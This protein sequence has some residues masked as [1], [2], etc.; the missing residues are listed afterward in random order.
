MRAQL[1]H[2]SGPL[3]GRTVT[4]QGQLVRIGAAA[5]NDVELPTAGVAAH[6]ATIEYDEPSC[7]FRLRRQ[8]GQ[9]FVNRQEVEEV[10]LD[11]DDLI[12]WGLNGPQSRCVG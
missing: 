5:G 7:C 2:L 8:D 3:R 1:L 10:V 4:Y 11:M 12:E 6:H 9:V